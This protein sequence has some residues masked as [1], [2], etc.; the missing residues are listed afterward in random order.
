MRLSAV[1]VA[2]TLVLVLGGCM[3]S[4][5]ASE[6]EPTV[7][8]DI[9]V[10]VPGIPDSGGW[11]GPPSRRVALGLFDADFIVSVAGGY[12]DDGWDGPWVSVGRRRYRPEFGRDFD[13][14]Q[15][16][17]VD[18]AG[19][20]VR[21]VA[22]GFGPVRVD[23]CGLEVWL[24]AGERG[25]GAAISIPESSGVPAVL[26]INVMFEGEFVH[27]EFITDLFA[28]VLNTATDPDGHRVS[29]CDNPEQLRQ[30][31]G[32]LIDGYVANAG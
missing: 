26:V 23:V 12:Q 4:D 30:E 1:L 24:H 6:R 21:A 28:R 22:V 17:N 18:H 3:A 27:A 32:A 16:A 13:L 14:F 9:S 5:D 7:F 2:F 19:G 25:A 31:L 10:V 8:G 20:G 15:L 29:T 11:Q